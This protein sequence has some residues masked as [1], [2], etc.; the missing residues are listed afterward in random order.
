MIDFYFFFSLG[1]GAPKTPKY[2]KKKKKLIKSLITR[3]WWTIIIFITFETAALLYCGG[4]EGEKE[5][6]GKFLNRGEKFR[7][8]GHPGKFAE[9]G[10]EFA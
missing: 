3:F 4:S 2:L 10:T 7:R 9:S 8:L 6:K 5:G 1:F